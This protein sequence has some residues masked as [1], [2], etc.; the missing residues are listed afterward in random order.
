MI[1]FFF[2]FMFYKQK[3]FLDR[4]SLF[5]SFLFFE[6]Q[7]FEE[8][9]KLNFKIKK[10]ISNWNVLNNFVFCWKY[11]IFSKIS[12]KKSKH[13]T[14]L[15]KLNNKYFT[16]SFNSCDILCFCFDLVWICVNVHS[17]H[18]KKIIVML[19]FKI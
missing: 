15:F 13:Q 1:H 5:C 4:K 7:I 19:N 18:F 14:K 17:T 6:F 8:K 12:F 2:I 3:D 9:S 11:L 16:Y 10:S